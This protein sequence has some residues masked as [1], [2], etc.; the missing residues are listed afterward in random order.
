M[1]K[2]A[3]RYMQGLSLHY[4]TTPTDWARKGSSTDYPVSEWDS[5]L[6][7]AYRMRT[8]LDRHC[9]IMDKYDPDKRVKLVVDEWGT[10]YNVEPGTN[11]GFLYQ[12]S[13]IR[14][15][16]V[17]ALTLHLFQE[18]NDRINMCCL[19]Q[20][21]N[22]LQSV[23]LTQGDQMV[24]T[25]TYHVF[26]M[27]KGHQDAERL[28]LEGPDIPLM[29][30]KVPQVTAGASQKNGKIL[31]TAANLSRNKTASLAVELR[32]VKAGRVAGRILTAPDIHT[33]NTFEDP[34]AVRPVSFD[35]AALRG[36]TLRLKLPAASVVALELE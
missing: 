26:E 29:E 32:G 17:A 1:M 2:N 18:K 22:V 12:Q 6:A 25:P 15:A 21:V 24:L 5:C 10:W 14:D 9:T 3:A 33:C 27:F 20:T 36:N 31:F 35:G 34:E 4:Y 13:T 11:P 28:E 23:I 16:M 19:A 8:L 30:N 7:N